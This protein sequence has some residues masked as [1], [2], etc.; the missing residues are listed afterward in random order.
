MHLI[1]NFPAEAAFVSVCMDLDS[2][3]DVDLNVCV[4]VRVCDIIAA[5]NYTFCAQC[6]MYMTKKGSGSVFDT[7]FV[8]F[9]FCLYVRC[10]SFFVDVDVV[11]VAVVECNENSIQTNVA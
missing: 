2:D 9:S 3:S 4:C 11:V 1:D 7:I 8:V 5:Y 6:T 10:F